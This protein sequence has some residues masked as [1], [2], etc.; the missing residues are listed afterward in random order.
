MTA[1]S[2]HACPVCGGDLDEAVRV[3]GSGPMCSRCLLSGR[4]LKTHPRPRLSSAEGLPSL[5]A[6]ADAALTAAVG[7]AERLL[8]KQD[9]DA[10]RAGFLSQAQQA[11]GE[12]RAFLAACLLF[13]A[14]RI[15]GQSARV[16]QALAEVALRL[17]FPREAVQYAKTA[18][19]LAMKTGDHPLAREVLDWIQVSSPQ[20][21]WLGKAREQFQASLSAAEVR[22]GFCGRTAREAGPLI[23][24][25][26]AAV[27]GA[28][29]RRMMNLDAR[30]N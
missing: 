2:P 19:W 5:S 22:C 15:P 21:P 10:G 4:F 26:S 16:Y 6:A 25:A 11:L 7:E 23:S 30:P 9:F 14:L 27:C 1:P 12:D 17:G 8:A 18:G 3:E 13:R 28:C 20:D 29:V 24:G